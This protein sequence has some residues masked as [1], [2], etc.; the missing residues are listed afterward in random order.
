MND[1]PR[2]TYQEDYFHS[3]FKRNSIEKNKSLD[4]LGLNL[5]FALKQVLTPQ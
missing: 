1:I 2:N 4:N 5:N 3:S